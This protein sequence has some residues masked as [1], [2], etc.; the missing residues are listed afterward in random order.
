MAGAKTQID[1]AL[2]NEL[3]LACGWEKPPKRER[4]FMKLVKIGS[5]IKNGCK[6]QRINIMWDGEC[7][8]LSSGKRIDDGQADTLDK[9]YELAAWLWISPAWGFT[10]FYR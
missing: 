10:P 4:E 5:I 1:K 7:L 6:A 2:T 9:A 3:Q 8:C